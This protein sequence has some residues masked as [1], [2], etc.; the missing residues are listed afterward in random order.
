MMEHNLDQ[1]QVKN[2]T[3]VLMNVIMIYSFKLTHKKKNN[4][5]K[6]LRAFSQTP[7]LV[8]KL[9]SIYQCSYL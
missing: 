1:H 3:N 5:I 4:K 7:F 6:S 2:P 9:V 8:K